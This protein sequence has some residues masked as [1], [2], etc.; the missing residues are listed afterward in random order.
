MAEKLAANKSWM[1]VC[2]YIGTQVYR[3]TGM[4]A[5]RYTGSQVHRYTDTQVNRC[6]GIQEYRYTGMI[7]TRRYESLEDICYVVIRSLEIRNRAM[8]WQ[9]KKKVLAKPKKKNTVK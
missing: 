8:H 9:K 1:E 4:Q 3:H 2:R 6:T 5:Y 7:I